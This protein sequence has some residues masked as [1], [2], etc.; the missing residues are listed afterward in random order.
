MLDV[1]QGDSFLLKGKDGGT[2]LVDGGRGSAVL[3]ELTN[4]LPTT[5]PISVI[6]ATHPDADHIEGLITV[7]DRYKVGAVIVSGAYSDTD[8]AKRLYAKVEEKK[9]PLLLGRTGLRI[10]LSDTEKKT[11]L[12]PDRDVTNWE[13]NASSIVSRFDAD[14]GSVLFTGDA[15]LSVEKYLVNHYKKHLDVDVLKLGHHGSRTS[16]AEIFVRAATPQLALISA[17]RNNSYGHPHKEVTD[18]LT[19]L[20]VPWVST[21]DTG[22]VTFFAEGGKWVRK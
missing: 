12:F 5:K 16:T 18:I 21:Q 6:I 19:R 7:L 10:S 8:V 3:G 14:G 9:V 11:I 2:I 1:G 20:K 17:G 13:T 4:V 15:P 22:T